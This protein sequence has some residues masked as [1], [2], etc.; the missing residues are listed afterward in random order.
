MPAAGA[1][2]AA[3]LHQCAGRRGVVGK[4]A[5][6]EHR[7]GARDLRRRSLDLG[8]PRGE[9]GV[10]PRSGRVRRPV[11][12]RFRRPARRTERR[13]RRLDDGLPAGA[14]TQV[15][16]ERA[17]DLVPTGRGAA[18]RDLAVLERSQTHEDPGCAE[19]ALAGSGPHEGVG[20]A[21]TLIGRQ[22]FEG[23]DP[24]TGDTAHRGDTR[25]AR[26]P[27]DPDGAAAALA[28]G[29]APVLDRTAAELLAEHV[30]ERD[31]VPDADGLPVQEE[32]DV[33]PGGLRRIRSGRRDRD[34]GTRGGGAIFAGAAQETGCRGLS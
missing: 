22:P 25:H 6:A 13:Q 17:L 29:A 18:S 15:G 10:L 20:P 34:S 12:V 1:A 27:V 19:P 28:L 16:P 9:H 7:L 4:P 33:G 30:E 26:D 2:S 23:G 31:P 24:A 32:R 21:V 14:T 11:L 3:E 8:A 5:S